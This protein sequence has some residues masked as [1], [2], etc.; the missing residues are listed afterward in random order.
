MPSPQCSCP[1]W[2]YIDMC[3]SSAMI[4]VSFTGTYDIN[5]FLNWTKPKKCLTILQ[6]VKKDTEAI[7]IILTCLH[8]IHS[9][10]DKIAINN[11]ADEPLKIN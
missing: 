5:V 10:N 3:C 4:C 6:P 8:S 1:F 2:I 9:L 7:D 11:T